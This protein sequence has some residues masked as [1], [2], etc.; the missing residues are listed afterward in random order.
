MYPRLLSIPHSQSKSAF[1]LGPRGTGKTQWIQTYF[2]EDIY[3]NLLDGSDYLRLQRA[4]HQLE[5]YIPSSYSGW[6]IIDEIQKIP[7]LLNEVHRLIESRRLKFILTGSSAR[8]LRE[9]GVNLLAG[10]AL[11][12]HMH[13]LTAT[14][15]GADFDLKTA[16]EVGL[17]PGLSA[18]EDKRHYLESYV[19]MYLREEV[20]QEGIVRSISDFNQ[21]LQ[22]ASFSQGC[23][24]NFSAIAREC[25]VSAKIVS[26]YFSILEDLLIGYFLP[27]FSRRAKRK[28][29]TAAKF[30]YFDT[31]VY[32]IL[33]PRGV[34]DTSDEIGGVAA[35]SLFLQ[36]LRAVNDYF[37][38]Y[39]NLYYWRTANGHEVDFV[40]YG[41][42][43]FHA[44]EIKTKNNLNS[45]DLKGLKQFSMDYPEAKLY[46]IYGG[47]RKL[48]LG[49]ITVLPFM[50][51]LIELPNLLQ[52]Q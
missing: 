22:V 43:G 20:M 3:I 36:H 45:K 24:V 34:L 27:V 26:G 11:R 23:P 40:A 5:Q 29:I 37:Q 46:L 50:D 52:G 8:S 32:Q 30:Y 28:L 13:P 47:D 41:E 7:A 18:E 10:R 33:R 12:Y 39:Y 38:L 2:K 21:F 44:F 17:L 4:P 6:V 14:E 49:N 35:E 25:G 31:G 19:Y 16:L 15:M 42:K 9:K 1:I 48:Y 51:A